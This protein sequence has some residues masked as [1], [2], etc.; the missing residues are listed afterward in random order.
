MADRELTPE[1]FHVLREHGTE[2]AGSSPLNQEKRAGTFRC[3]GCGEPL[4]SS[5]TKFESGTGWPSFYAP[6]ERSGGD[7][8]RSD[9]RHDADRGPLREMR[10]SSR[11][12]VSRRS[13]ADRAALLHERTRPRVRT[14]EVDAYA[15]KGSYP[16]SGGS[17]RKRRTTPFR[18][19]AAAA[20]AGVA[21]LAPRVSAEAPLILHIKDFAT[22]PITGSTTGTG[23]AGSLARINMMREEPGGAGRLFV[24]DLNGPFY[25]ID[26]NTKK[27]TTYLNF[28]GRDGRSPACS[29]S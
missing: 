2:R 9:V 11:P 25:I 4:F 15:R 27:F 5:D 8:G 1:Q 24:N 23:N 14:R 21:F 10:R 19:L 26:K 12:R 29:T 16:F 6:L 17:A 18:W 22:A 7:D 28:N 13:A 20:V 3:A